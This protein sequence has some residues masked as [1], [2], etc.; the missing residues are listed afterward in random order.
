LGH[1]RGTYPTLENSPEPVSTREFG[2]GTEKKRKG[3]IPQMTST[4][5]KNPAWVVKTKRR[6]EGT[7]VL[8]GPVVPE[9][10]L[11][12]KGKEKL[13]LTILLYGRA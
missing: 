8:K 13:I 4:C 12:R 10:S 11:E 1:E 7:R 3:Y 9:R 5:Q 2:G 6:E